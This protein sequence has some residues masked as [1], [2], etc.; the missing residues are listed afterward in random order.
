MNRTDISEEG[1]L[2]KERD[3]NMMMVVGFEN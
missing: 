3:L 1:R 2:K